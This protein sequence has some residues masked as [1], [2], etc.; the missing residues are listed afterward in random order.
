MEELRGED[1]DGVGY[2]SQLVLV[3]LTIDTRPLRRSPER[4]FR[5]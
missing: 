2:F 4:S 1:D 5:R 3:I